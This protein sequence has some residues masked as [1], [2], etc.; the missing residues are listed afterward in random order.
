MF[1]F[2][3]KFYTG[4]LIFYITSIFFLSVY[5][6]VKW[7]FYIMKNCYS[8]IFSNCYFVNP[9]LN[10]LND[11]VK[12]TVLWQ[13][14][15]KAF[16]CQVKELFIPQMFS[17]KLKWYCRHFKTE[18][19]FEL[20]YY[21]FPAIANYDTLL[22]SGFDNLF[23]RVSLESCNHTIPLIFE[24]LKLMLKYMHTFDSIRKGLSRIALTTLN[25]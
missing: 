1:F 21:K 25:V 17:F 20:F 18:E 12:L 2:Q 19:V 4:F 9:Q 22:Y 14:I 3:F 10:L 11:W 16:V 23:V 5:L 8:Y 7:L 13:F 15:C 6:L 24:C